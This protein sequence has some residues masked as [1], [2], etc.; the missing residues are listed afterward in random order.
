M[1]PA[2]AGW[3]HW[4]LEST[5]GPDTPV[6]NRAQ[7]CDSHSSRVA[8]P[9]L[10]VGLPPPKRASLVARSVSEGTWM[11]RLAV[12]RVLLRSCRRIAHGYLDCDVDPFHSIHG[13]APC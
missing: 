7:F 2:D 5:V 9:R 6:N 13:A 4:G 8:P 11:P 10:R 12:G 1:S 3:K